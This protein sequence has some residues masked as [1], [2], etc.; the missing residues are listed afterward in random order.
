MHQSSKPTAIPIPVQTHRVNRVLTRNCSNHTSSPT[1]RPRPT[2]VPRDGIRTLVWV[3]RPQRP[4]SRVLTSTRSAHSPVR[5]LSVV[6]SCLVSLCL[7]R[8]TV[9]LLSEETTCTTF[10]STTDTRRD[11]RTS[12]STSPQ[13][14]VSRSVTLSLS[15]NVDQSPR[16]LDS[17]S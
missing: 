3:S 8:C 15:V 16:L 13:L 14:S 11:T 1:Q 12:Q 6:R 9:P 7:P 4:P 5:S 2:D 17:T 10:Q